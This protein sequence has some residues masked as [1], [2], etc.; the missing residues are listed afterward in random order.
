MVSLLGIL[1]VLMVGWL[2]IADSKDAESDGHPGE[3]C[4][5]ST[6]AG[7]VGCAGSCQPA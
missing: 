7:G 4:D 2:A 5:D 3:G 6:D 1:C